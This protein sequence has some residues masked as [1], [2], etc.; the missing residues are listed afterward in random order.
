MHGLYYISYN[1]GISGPIKRKLIFSQ[2]KKLHYF[3][4]MIQETHLSEKLR[5]PA[6]V[7]KISAT[8]LVMMDELGLVVIWRYTRF[9]FMLQ[10]HGSAGYVF[11][12]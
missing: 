3:I 5:L 4:A 7:S 8:L 9:T 12:I 10:V 2:L 1:V 6:E 11:D